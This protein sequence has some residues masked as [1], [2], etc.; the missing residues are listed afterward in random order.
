MIGRLFA[1]YKIEHN[2]KTVFFVLDR[3]ANGI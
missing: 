2:K 3:L 1:Y